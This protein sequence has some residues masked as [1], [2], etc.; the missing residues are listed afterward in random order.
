MA[1][2]ALEAPKKHKQRLTKDDV[3]FNTFN[4]ILIFFFVAITLYPLIYVVSASISEPTKVNSGEMWLY[5]VGFTT[6][7]YQKVFKDPDIWRGYA[8]TIYYT[9]F[10][11]I[12]NLAFTLPCAY[13]LTKKGLPFRGLIS[14]VILFT[15]FFSG[16]L[17]PLYMLVNNLRLL[18]T[19]WA[20][21]L[22]TAVSAY[23]VII[24]RTFM[25]NSIPAGLEEAAEID[26]CSPFGVF[27]RIILPLS[28][29]IIAV[30]ALFYGVGHWNS[31]FNEMIFLSSNSKMPLQVV[32]RELII[33]TQISS[34]DGAVIS[35][36][37]AKT[38]AEMQQLAGV[39]KYSVMIV[40][41]VPIICVYP[42]LQRFFVK[43][44]MIGSIKG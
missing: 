22:P 13:A 17:I 31:Y 9:G 18:D 33:I 23:N 30:M 5:P 3:L 8:N 2:K 39:I 37:E 15:M 20:V 6:V 41:T 7:G 24:T 42:F 21:V 34:G 32:L 43:G 40:S 12:V 26:G 35:N 1:A 19:V 4:Y 11:T 28:A 44:V 38:A 36:T 10:G 27:F 25:E 16:G 14:F 29:P